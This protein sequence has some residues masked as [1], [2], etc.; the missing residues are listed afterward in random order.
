MVLVISKIAEVEF[1]TL[2]G[3]SSVIIGLIQGRDS[4]R[5]ARIG[6]IM[7]EVQ[8]KRI[9]QYPGC[10]WCCSGQGRND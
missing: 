4:E 3:L 8:F 9:F 2:Y 10:S 7:D 5:I 6:G 1:G